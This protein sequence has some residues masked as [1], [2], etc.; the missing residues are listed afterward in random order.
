MN[1]NTIKIVYILKKISIFHYWASKF[2]FKTKTIFRIDFLL[3]G[4]KFQNR[5]GQYF[6]PQWGCDVK[7]RGQGGKSKVEMGHLLE[8]QKKAFAQK[9]IFPKKIPRTDVSLAML[10]YVR[11]VLWQVDLF[12][13]SKLKESSLLISP[14]VYIQLG[15]FPLVHVARTTVK[16]GVYDDGVHLE[17]I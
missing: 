5:L 14:K 3:S 11:C 2:C 8:P 16:C 15:N 1:Y 12:F 4:Q 7:W 13:P 17:H 6:S 9:T 10:E